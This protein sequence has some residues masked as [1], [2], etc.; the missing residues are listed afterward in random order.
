M[1]VTGLNTSPALTGGFIFHFKEK[2]RETEGT[3][4]QCGFERRPRVLP[5]ARLQ[6]RVTRSEEQ[7]QVGFGASQTLSCPVN[8]AFLQ[9][10][11]PALLLSS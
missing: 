1:W 3:H 7:K 10:R 11:V 6:V 2:D 8:T 5:E 9:L 4:A